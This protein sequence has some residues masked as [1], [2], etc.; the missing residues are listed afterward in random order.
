MRAPARVYLPVRRSLSWL[1]S[2]VAPLQ[3]SIRLMVDGRA[4]HASSIKRANGV[5][6]VPV[7]GVGFGEWRRGIEGEKAW[8]QRP[9]FCLSILPAGRSYNTASSFFPL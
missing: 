6:R 8:Q 3:H 2:L 9:A 5:R 1:S 7:G 4:Q